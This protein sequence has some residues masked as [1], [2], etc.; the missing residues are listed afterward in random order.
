MSN[1]TRPLLVLLISMSLAAPAAVSGQGRF[2]Y[3]TNSDGSSITITGYDGFGGAITIPTNI[4][5]LT[6]TS[7]GQ[8]AFQGGAPM[9]SVTIP[10]TVTNIGSEA[11]GGCTQMTNVSMGNGIVDIEWNAFDDCASLVNITIPKSVT[12]LG[13]STFTDCTAL[14]GVF[15]QGNAPSAETIFVAAHKATVYYLPMTTGWGSKFN[16]QPALLWNAHPDR[17]WKFRRH[18]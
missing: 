5:G 9:T 7:I 16:G 13:E 6:V 17:R 11:F 8:T 2:E 4:N 10:D 14:T 15:F 3:T 1:V 12:N 18:Q